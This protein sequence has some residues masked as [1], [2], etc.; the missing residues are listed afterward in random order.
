MFSAEC[1]LTKK[2]KKKPKILHVPHKSLTFREERL[3]EIYNEK[4]LLIDYKVLSEAL[5]R[6]MLSARSVVVAG[7]LFFLFNRTSNYCQLYQL[8]QKHSEKTL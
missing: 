7:L 8:A 3:I 5:L 1:F 4:V 2:T 6:P